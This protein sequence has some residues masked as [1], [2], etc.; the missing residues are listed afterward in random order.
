MKTHHML[1]LQLIDTNYKYCTNRHT[2]NGLKLDNRRRVNA[3]CSYVG[4]IR[5]RLIFG[6]PTHH[7]QK[8]DKLLP[9]FRLIF[10]QF[11]EIQFQSSTIRHE[12]KNNFQNFMKRDS[13]NI[14]MYKEK[15]KEILFS[16]IP[17]Q[18]KQLLSIIQQ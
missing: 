4:Y 12:G 10:Q 2:H 16:Y 3:C 11:L 17:Q 18:R 9:L 5:S 13:N 1:H 8:Q 6:L 7:Y 15:N 14:K